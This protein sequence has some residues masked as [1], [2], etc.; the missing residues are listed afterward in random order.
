M[1][2]GALL[3]RTAPKAAAG[4]LKRGFPISLSLFAAINLGVFSKY[5]AILK[6]QPSMVLAALVVAFVLAGIYLVAGLFCLGAA[7]IRDRAG[8]AVSMANMNNVLVIVL[9][10]Q[11]FGA[12]EPTLAA[13]YMFPFFAVIVPLR[14]IIRKRENAR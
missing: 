14:V 8:A 13:M 2:L 6:Q 12:I 1:I 10:S 3:R 9:A 11:F 7:P 4:L 5:S